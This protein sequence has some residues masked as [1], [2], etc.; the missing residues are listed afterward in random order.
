MGDFEEENRGAREASVL[1]GRRKH[2]L[3][4]TIAFGVG[5]LE[6]VAGWKPSKKT[7]WETSVNISYYLLGDVGTQAQ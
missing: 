7:A 3:K 2:G 1:S 5:V 4:K 6:N